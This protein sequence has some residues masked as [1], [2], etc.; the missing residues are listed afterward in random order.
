[1]NCENDS[2][3]TQAN[4]MSLDLEKGLPRVGELRRQVKFVVQPRR[5]PAGQ[6]HRRRADG[7]RPFAPVQQVAS[8]QV[9]AELAGVPRASGERLYFGGRRRLGSDEDRQNIDAEREA[10]RRGR[11]V[12]DGQQYELL[13][14]DLQ[15]DHLLA[16]CSTWLSSASSTIGTI[17]NSITSLH[18]RA[19][20]V[21]AAAVSLS[22]KSN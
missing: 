20:S 10:D 12:R 16:R 13:H 5:E 14:C 9:L 11:G 1:M 21:K 15:P 8:P 6:R 17:L 18:M 3:Q 22:S 7:H 4:R 19:N 2:H